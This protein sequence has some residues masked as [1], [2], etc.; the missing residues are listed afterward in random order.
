MD[1]IL[2]KAAMATMVSLSLAST[3]NAMPLSQTAP[4]KELQLN[5]V[6]QVAQVK[7]A[8]STLSAKS[9]MILEMLGQYSQMRKM[10]LQAMKSSD[11]EMRKMG[12]AMVKTSE[13]EISRLVKM[14]RAEFLAN[15]DR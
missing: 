4:S 3:V 10:G 6:T 11:P 9:E 5:S 13:T 1:A 12:E 2:S 7:V 14:M 8:Q 15:P